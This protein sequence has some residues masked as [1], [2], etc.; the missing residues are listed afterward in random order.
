MVAVQRVYPVPR[1]SDQ[2][3]IPCAPAD[4]Q[5]ASIWHSSC[6]N[7]LVH[8]FHVYGHSVDHSPVAERCRWVR[9]PV[10]GISASAC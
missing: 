1:H 7:L 6:C 4:Q 3:Q 9:E 8:G 10:D 5:V 2:L